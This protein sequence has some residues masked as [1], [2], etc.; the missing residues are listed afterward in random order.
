L[1]VLEIEKYLPVYT[2]FRKKKVSW[3]LFNLSVLCCVG[4]SIFGISKSGSWANWQFQ[5]LTIRRL[6]R[7]YCHFVTRK[8]YFIFYL[9]ILV[10][11][12]V[13]VVAAIMEAVA[14]APE[15][16]LA[17]IMALASL[18]PGQDHHFWTQGW[19]PAAQAQAVPPLAPRIL[20]PATTNI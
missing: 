12:T 2:R 6:M 15:R 18:A 10:F 11:I 5:M 1:L 13:A 8:S 4:L 7:F 19:I 3:Y 14:T 17:Q 16:A 20:L 9:R